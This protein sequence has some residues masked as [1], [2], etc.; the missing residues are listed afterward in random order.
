LRALHLDIFEQ[1]VQNRVFQQAVKTTNEGGLT[2]RKSICLLTAVCVALFFVGAAFA[3]EKGTAEATVQLLKPQVDTQPFLQLLNKRA[4]TRTY[5]T[6]PLPM[7]TLSDILWAAFGISRTDSGKRTAPTA[8]NKQEI[9]I[10]A[11]MEKGIYLYDAKANQ[12]NLVAAG[13][14]RAAAGTQAYVKDV[15][16]NL[17]YVADMSK[18]GGKTDDIKLLYAAA[19]TGFISENVY[20]YCASVGLG[21]VIRAYVDRPPLAQILKLRPDQKIILAQTVGYPKP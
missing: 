14:H 19:A 9:D 2:M 12:L 1:P 7:Q 18:S 20:L 8:N 21:T 17:I 5:T 13:D 3:A 10:Y 11:V 15:P 16:L 6:Q 4:S